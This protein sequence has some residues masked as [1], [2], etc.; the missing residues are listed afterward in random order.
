MMV[1]EFRIARAPDELEEI[2]KLR[3]QIYSSVGYIK[4]E[5]YPDEKEKDE[6]DEFSDHFY[7][8]STEENKIIGAI[9]LINDL[10][11]VPIDELYNISFLRNQHKK[12]VEVSRRITMPNRIKANLGLL[13]IIC[14]Y[15]RKN[16]ITDFICSVNPNDKDFYDKIGFV[17]FGE[18]KYYEK[19]KNSALGMHLDLNKMNSPYNKL[20]FKPSRNIILD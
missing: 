2:Y 6:F 1:L 7:A 10:G 20:F 17:Q 19:V 8:Y 12:I 14:Q 13:Q 9:R 16:N 18:L 15:A 4:K 3:F 11:R 5:D